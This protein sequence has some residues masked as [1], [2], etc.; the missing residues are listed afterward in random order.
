MIDKR[1]GAF[2]VT[3]SFFRAA[4]ALPALEEFPAMTLAPGK[5]KPI[6]SCD[7]SKMAHN[8]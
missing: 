7:V 5:L 2:L 4:V 8:R 3:H 6:Q 1:L